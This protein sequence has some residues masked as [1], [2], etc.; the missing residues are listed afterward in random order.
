MSNCPRC[1][2]VVS[3]EARFCANCGASLLTSISPTPAEDSRLPTTPRGAASRVP[4]DPTP[5]H[6]GTTPGGGGTTPADFVAGT[7][8]AERYRIVGTIGRGGMGEVFRADDLKLQQPVALKFLPVGLEM[9]P[10]RLERLFAEVRLARQISHTAVCR[11]FDIGEVDGRHFLTMEYVDGENLGS[12]LR[13]VGR[14]PMERATEMARQLCAG[15]AAAHE[16]GIL[17][18]DLKPHNVLVDGKGK[19][20]IVD[21]GLAAAAEAFSGDDVRSGTPSYMAPEQVTGKGVTVRSDIYSLGLVL[22]ELFTGKKAITGK[23]LAEVTRAHD[24]QLLES[25]SRIVGDMDPGVERAIL[26]CL[27]KDPEMRP[28]SALAVAAALPG[29]DPVAAALAAG[30][31]PSPEMVAALGRGQVMPLWLARGCLLAVALGLLAFPRI[32]PSGRLI[33]VVPPPK[34]PAALT[35]RAQDI[36]GRLQVAEAVDQATSFA[37]DDDYYQHVIDGHG[38][39]DAWSKLRTGEPPVLLFWYRQGARPL[40]PKG[41]SG[42]VT[43]RE[44]PPLEAG[45]AG[46]RLDATGRLTGFYAVPPQR[47]TETAASG[48]VDWKPLFDEARLDIQA[49]R[50]VEPR[51]TPPFYADDRVAWEGHYASDPGTPLRVEAASY[52]GRPAWFQL[53]SP[54]S[55][56]ERQEPYWMSAMERVGLS[57][58]ILLAV[59]IV[60]AA[61]VMA[62]R[63]LR[64][65][66]CDTRGAG[67]VAAYVFAITALAWLISAH[68]VASQKG[69]LGLVLEGLGWDLLVCAL[70]GVF[71]LA[72]EPYVRRLWPRV[73]VSWTR[74]IGGGLS[75]PLVGQDALIGTA[76]GMATTLL[77]Y[78]GL[79]ISSRFGKQPPPVADWVDTFLGPWSVLENLLDQQAISFLVSLMFLLLLVLLRLLLR[80]EGLAAAAFVLLYAVVQTLGSPWPRDVAAFLYIALGCGLCFLF[81]RF[82]LVAAL[83]TLWVTD[84]LLDTP[85]VSDLRSWT[86]SPTLWVMAVVMAVAVYGYWA[87][88]HGRPATAF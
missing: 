42:K 53:V 33:G 13:R 5:G 65:G 12:L 69:E 77:V 41:P 73:L 35:D 50:R 60:V 34:P 2:A 61:I 20:R 82:G 74:L 24:E 83:V 22:Y 64:L 10:T 72:L 18:R 85:W 75:D 84:T 70:L 43:W 81:L 51:W 57:L 6:S 88:R 48:T 25:P 28:A 58:T 16:K 40:I 67:R 29:G 30:E 62:R 71:Y 31:T 52:G 36:L 68:H 8:V 37:V 79:G 14:V 55:R 9:D 3:A 17:H 46:V 63:N 87:A 86:A 45:M 78:C 56:A 21:F 76:V 23:T 39:P 47:E 32:N 38:P 11:V 44:P 19:V 26:R 49:F 54:W 59:L 27:E 7:L 1:R 80:R 4:S 66:R 15:L